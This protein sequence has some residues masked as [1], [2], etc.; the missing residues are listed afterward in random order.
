MTTSSAD[1]N[2]VDTRIWRDAGGS[3]DGTAPIAELLTVRDTP[4]VEPMTE[5]ELRSIAFA[6]ADGWRCFYP[7]A[8]GHLTAAEARALLRAE[9][10]MPEETA[11]EAV[12]AEFLLT[13]ENG[14]AGDSE[15]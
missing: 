8:R 11:E 5:A 14:W 6:D 3:W 13:M 9:R 15:L 10:G 7:A 4:P 2:D 1:R 12:A